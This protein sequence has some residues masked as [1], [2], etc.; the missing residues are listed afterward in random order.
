AVVFSASE[1]RRKQWGGT[2]IGK[3]N[4]PYVLGVLVLGDRNSGAC[5]RSGCRL[6]PTQPPGSRLPTLRSP[7]HKP[8]HLVCSKLPSL[9]SCECVY[10]LCVAVEFG[11]VA[12]YSPLSTAHFG[13]SFR[14]FL[15][16]FGVRVR[17]QKKNGQSVQ[18][19]N[20]RSVSDVQV[21]Q[22]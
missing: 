2:R 17:G 16:R 11:R 9:T 10:D 8:P 12:A 21:S 1:A 5:W 3:T 20:S 14:L 7:T 15:L 4:P 22:S 18:K 19:K 13:L 6:A